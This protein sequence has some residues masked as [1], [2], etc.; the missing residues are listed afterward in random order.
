ME[1]WRLPLVLAVVPQAAGQMPQVQVTSWGLLEPL[2]FALRHRHYYYITLRLALS[3]A[4]YPSII[5]LSHPF[6]LCCKTRVPRRGSNWAQGRVRLR[7]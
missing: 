7:R 6:I 2:E 5:A 1:F 4:C 3:T